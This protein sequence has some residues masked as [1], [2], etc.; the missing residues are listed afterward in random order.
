MRWKTDGERQVQW[1]CNNT[2][3]YDITLNWYDKETAG[4]NVGSSHLDPIS[5]DEDD[6]EE[7]DG[8][9]VRRCQNEVEKCKN[10]DEK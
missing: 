4:V 10:D 7:N 1:H 8:G 9:Y 3:L 2:L 6:E 5:S